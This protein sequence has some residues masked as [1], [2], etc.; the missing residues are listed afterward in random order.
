MPRRSPTPLPCRWPAPAPSRPTT[1]SSPRSSWTSIPS[2]SPRIPPSPAARPTSRWRQGCGRCGPRP[3]ACRAAAAN[4]ARATAE[5]EDNAFYCPDERLHRLRRRRA[6]S[7]SWTTGLRALHGRHGAGPRVGSRHPGPARLLAAGRDHRAPGRLLRRV[8]DGPG[9]R[10]RRGRLQLS[11]P[12]CASPSRASSSSA[13]RRGPRRDDAGRPRQRLRPAGQ[14]PGRPGGR[15]RRPAR[16]TRPRRRSCSS[17]PSTAST[18]P[19]TQGDMPLDDAG[20]RGAGRPRP[21]LGVELLRRSGHDLRRRSAGRSRA[22]PTAA[23]TRRCRGL[24]TADFEQWRRLLPEPRVRRLRADGGANARLHDDHRRLL[25]RRAVRRPLGRGRSSTVSACAPTAARPRSSATASPVSGWRTSCPGRPGQQEFRHLARR[26]RRGR[27]DVPALHRG[28]RRVGRAG[29]GPHRLV[30]RAACS[31]AWR[32]AASDAVGAG[33]TLDRHGRRPADA[34]RHRR[35]HQQLPPRRGPGDGRGPLRGHHQREGDGAARHRQR[36][37][38]AT[39]A[40]R[41]RSGA[42]RRCDG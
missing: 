36:R 33:S 21:L 7:P 35:R 4:A 29:P 15:T 11:D 8:V 16:R 42:S 2:G 38:E 14:L 1:R 3:K 39:E 5:I 32:A 28:R 17:C 37:H 23:R 27:P 31:R 22:T 26:S 24:T 20:Q 30:P 13:T 18:T 40:R 25:G 10:R 12:T 6:S 19:Q 41:H 34:R 9:P